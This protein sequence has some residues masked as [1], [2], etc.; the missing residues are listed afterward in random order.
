MPLVQPYPPEET[1]DRGKARIA[2]PSACSVELRVDQTEFCVPTPPT[3][4]VLVYD[5]ETTT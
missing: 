5:F 3:V 4:A 2:Q 1:V